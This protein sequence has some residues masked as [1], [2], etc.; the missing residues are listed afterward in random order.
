[1][2]ELHAGP[3]SL[4]LWIGLAVVATLL[5]YPAMAHAYMWALDKITGRD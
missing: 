3:E 2:V 4:R 1:M 5:L